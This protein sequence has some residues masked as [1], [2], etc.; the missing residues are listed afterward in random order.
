MIPFA[1]E[2]EGVSEEGQGVWALAVDREGILT[3]NRSR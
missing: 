1:V 3:A 2:I